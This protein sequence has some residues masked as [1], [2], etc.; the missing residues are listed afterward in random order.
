MKT[1]VSTAITILTL[2]LL[3]SAYAGD[4]RHHNDDGHHQHKWWAP[5]V[6]RVEIVVNPVP[7]PVYA[8]PATDMP[9]YLLRW[10]NCYV[11]RHNYWDPYCAYRGR[12]N[13]QQ[14]GEDQELLKYRAPSVVVVVA[15]PPPQA[16]VPAPAVQATPPTPSWYYC[17]NPQGYYPYVQQCPSGWQPVAITPQ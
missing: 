3:S 9:D 1:T 5:L 4:K 6:P 14:V 12:K 15:P 11:N 7:V 13:G 17:H 2:L 10:P 8:A 16:P